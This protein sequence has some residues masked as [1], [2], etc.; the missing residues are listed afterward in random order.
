MGQQVYFHRIR[1]ITDA[2][3][4]RGLT[5]AIREGDVAAST[6]FQY[7]TSPEFL[8]RYLGY[9]DDGLL[10]A[11]MNSGQPKIQDL[12]RRLLERRLFKQICE[13]PLEQVNAVARDRLPRL[14]LGTAEASALEKAIGDRLGINPD[15]VIANKWSVSKPPFGSASDRLD[16]EEI[17]IID[18]DD[19]PRKVRDF[20]GLSI[21]FKA[22]AESPQT[23]QVF[24]PRDDWNDPEADTRAE[25][26]E[27]QQAVRDILIQNVS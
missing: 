17:L 8:D 24:A 10:R 13:L 25:R 9:D 12:F 16:P 5:I 18:W 23:I 22:I 27:C 6:L 26:E 2:M 19:I 20:P 4:V 11:L 7:D 1:A 3:L 14:E 21:D 15:F